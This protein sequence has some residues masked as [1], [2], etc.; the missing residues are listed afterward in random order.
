MTTMPM[1][2]T[3]WNVTIDFEENPDSTIA[4]ATLTAPT[5]RELKGTGRA[6]RNPGDRPVARI[7]EEVACARAL[8]QLTHSLLD[9]AA[10]EIEMNVRRGD[11][12]P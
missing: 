3:S 2:K 7:G 9:Y 10:T 1:L 4:T 6:R 8:S 12:V 5:G 11:P